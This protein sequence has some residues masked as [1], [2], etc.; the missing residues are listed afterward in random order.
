MLGRLTLIGLSWLLCT[1]FSFAYIDPGYHNNQE[2]YQEII[3][4][5][6]TY[7]DTVRVDTIG[8][9]ELDDLPIWGVKISDNVDQDEDEVTVLFVGQVHAEELIGV[10]IT[11]AFIGEILENRFQLPY[12]A[13]L[14]KLEIWVVPTAN[15]EGHAVVMTDSMDNSFRKNKRDCN[16][17]GI[18]DYDSTGWG[19]D[20][21]GVDINRNFPL[22]WVKGDT[23]L[24]QGGNEFYDYFRGFS[25]LSESEN[26]SLWELAE[27]EKF[28]FSIVW[29]SSRTGN[30]SE[31][32]FYSWEWNILKHPPDWEMINSLAYTVAENIPKINPIYNYDP[33]PTQSPVGNQHDSFYAHF[34]TISFLIEAGPG[35]QYPYTTVV[36]VI[37]DNLSGAGV[38]LNRASGYGS[39]VQHSQLT[40]LVTDGVSGLPI[41][42]V[43]TLPNFNNPILTSRTCEPTYGRYRRFVIPG[44]YTIELSLRGYETQTNTLTANAS[45]PTVWNVALTPK[46]MHLFHGTVFDVY[47]GS[48]LSG[49]LY[50]YGENVADTLEIAADGGIWH[51]LPEG[52]YQLIFD[53]PGYIVRFDEI[54]L[55]QNRYIEFELSPGIVIFSD[56]FESG[57]DDW[58]PGGT[59]NLWLTE[60]APST[61]PGGIHIA[62]S[63]PNLTDYVSYSENWIE[64]S[65]PL[66]LSG[67]ATASLRFLHW[68]YFE[69]GYD[70]C[71]VQASADGGSNW[72]TIAGP[73]YGQNI[74]WGSGYASLHSYCGLSDVRLRWLIQTDASL[75]EQGWRIDDV[76]VMV[77][78]TFVFVEPG[79]VTPRDMALCTVFPNP[80]N[81]ELA[82]VMDLAG[83]EDVSLTLWDI[84]GRQV[85]EIYSGRLFP[86]TKQLHW[87]APAQQSSG[88]YLLQIRTESLRQVQK[89]LYLK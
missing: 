52:E 74:G 26:Q 48:P 22:N 11:L 6:Q 38:L 46:P 35:I 24:H 73:F 15:P 33:I 41:P 62:A 53:F 58:T 66:D 78:D 37:E 21:D 87:A 70:S 54:N 34:G 8:Y 76:E 9:S 17:N 25:P 79:V 89:V 55:D 61:L 40:G 13:W 36:Q 49:T 43:V 27:R 82:I 2:I 77:A 16:E 67:K 50:I 29:H 32:I 72:E 51:D 88:I 44:T 65:Q 10:E 12:R 56:D 83:A 57:L 85:A 75:N 39:N 4:W 80:F 18:F 30:F 69:P 84:S 3:T 68:F 20:I 71:Q 63:S 1:A 42:A 86:G 19:G 45:S 47:S 5:G 28:S 14:D 59:N 60:L 81:S 64:I 23:F 7:P 31:K